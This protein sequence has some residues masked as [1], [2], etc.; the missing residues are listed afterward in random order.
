M[1]LVIRS[2]MVLVL[3]LCANPMLR[4]A[5]NFAFAAKRHWRYPESWIEQWRYG[6]STHFADENGVARMKPEWLQRW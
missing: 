6:I 4:A 5:E 3:S 1:N 2:S